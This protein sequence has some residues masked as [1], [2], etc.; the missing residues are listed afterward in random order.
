MVT[1]SNQ[2]VLKKYYAIYKLPQS[3]FGVFRQLYILFSVKGALDN[4][5]LIPRFFFQKS[6]FL[7]Y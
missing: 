3:T 6:W 5:S 7:Y 1:F 2:L 4:F